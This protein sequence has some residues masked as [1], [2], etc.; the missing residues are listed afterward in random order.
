[1]ASGE[2]ANV[3]NFDLKSEYYHIDIHKEHQKYLGFAWDFDGKTR[4]FSFAVFP[5][6]L[7]RAGHIFTKVVR[8]IVKYVLLFQRNSTSCFSR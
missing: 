8:E 7:S 3:I 1:M 4:Y 2:H 6:G 5:F